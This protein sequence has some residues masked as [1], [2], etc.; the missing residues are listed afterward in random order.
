MDRLGGGCYARRLAARMHAPLRRPTSGTLL[1]VLLLVMIASCALAPRDEDDFIVLGGVT[2]Q[3]FL[4]V[5]EFDEL[6]LSVRPGLGEVVDVDEPTLP[7]VGG[8]VQRPLN[9]SRVEVGIEGG[10]SFAWGDGDALVAVGGGGALVVADNDLFLGDLF[11]GPYARAPLGSRLQVYAAAGPL[12]QYGR[13]ELDYRNDLDEPVSLDDDG[14]G[15][16]WYARAGFELALDPGT[17]IGLGARWVDSGVDLGD[18]FD[19]YDFEALQLLL[20]MSTR[21]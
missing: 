2:A 21:L 17:W 16:G 1:S 5:A 18:G 7:L 15:L 11:G 3:G 8:V 10:L 20:T 6:D 19:D 9:S 12:L 13:A 14:F 4:G